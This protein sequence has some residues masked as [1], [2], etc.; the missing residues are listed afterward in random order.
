MNNNSYYIALVPNAKISEEI[1]KLKLDAEAKFGT[2]LAL[3][4]PAHITLVPPFTANDEELA[5]VLLAVNHQVKRHKQLH[6]TIDD[7]DNFGSHTIFLQIKNS[8]Q[9]SKLFEELFVQVSQLV[10]TTDYKQFI[11]HITLAN[12]DIPAESFS[13]IL[14]YFKANQQ[15]RSKRRGC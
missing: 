15:P 7:R 14:A 10:K 1:L 6:I 3:R 11:P 5:H 8:L 4:S 13:K 2:K 9:L 12:R